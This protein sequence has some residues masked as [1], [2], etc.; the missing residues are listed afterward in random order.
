MAKAGNAISGV[1]FP[2]G[3]PLAP[4]GVTPAMIFLVDTLLQR[5]KL[6]HRASCQCGPA[7]S[8]RPEPLLSTSNRWERLREGRKALPRITGEVAKPIEQ[9]AHAV[10]V[11][12]HFRREFLPS[13]GG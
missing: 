9:I 2:I 1:L 7:E 6:A 3:V 12:A 10:V 4:S 11:G 13:E 8:P 5:C